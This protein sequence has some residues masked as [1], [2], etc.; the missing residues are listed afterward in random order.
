MHA[1]TNNDTSIRGLLKLV[2]MMPDRVWS[3]ALFINKIVRSTHTADLRQPSHLNTKQWTDTVFDHQTS[4]CD[5]EMA[6]EASKFKSSKF[7]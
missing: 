3:N 6:G 4:V 1:V 7:P 2:L 5:L